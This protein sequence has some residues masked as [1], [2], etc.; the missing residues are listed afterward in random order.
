MENL[1]RCVADEALSAVPLRRRRDGGGVV[2][3]LDVA[4]LA[5]LGRVDEGRGDEDD[6]RLPVAAAHARR[7]RHVDHVQVPARLGR[8]EIDNLS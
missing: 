1:T 7:P 3:D 8:G 4:E 5:P 6:H 2:G